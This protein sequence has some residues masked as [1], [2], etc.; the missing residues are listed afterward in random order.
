MN[1]HVVIQTTCD[2][3]RVIMIKSDPIEA[4][5]YAREAINCLV[6]DLQHDA[7]VGL[8]LEERPAPRPKIKEEFGTYDQGDYMFVTEVEDFDWML[9]VHPIYVDL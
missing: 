5:N 6:S 3:S 7:S 1:Y 8:L 9:T 2:E 4:I